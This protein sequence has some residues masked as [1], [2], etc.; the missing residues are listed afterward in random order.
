VTRTLVGFAVV[1]LVLVAAGEAFRRASLIEERLATADEQLT[2]DGRIAPEV[3]TALD[4]AAGSLSRVP[5]LGARLERAIR[6][7]RAEAA[8]WQGDYTALAVQPTPAGTSTAEND[9]SLLLI[10]ANASFRRAVAQN[11]TPQTLARALDDVLKAYGTVLQANPQST[12]A[13][14]DYEYVARLRAVLAAGR[15]AA[16]PAPRTASMQGEEGEPPMG[17]KN[18]DF[19]VIVPLRPEERQDQMDPGAGATFKRKG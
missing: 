11:R 6:Y 10:A 13:A 14:F 17:N 1:V 5:I 4:A 16:V 7:Q 3:T 19:N 12:D 8:Y 9:P 2:T 15:G 18:A